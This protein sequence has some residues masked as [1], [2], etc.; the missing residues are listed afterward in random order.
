[1]LN[2]CTANLIVSYH[3]LKLKALSL[4]VSTTQMVRAFL[5][6]KQIPD[7]SSKIITVSFDA[8]KNNEICITL[9][10]QMNNRCA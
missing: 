2:C 3:H 1:M 5:R 10:K 6:Q 4:F 8:A 9:I 7:V